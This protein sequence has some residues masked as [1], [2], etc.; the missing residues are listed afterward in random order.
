MSERNAEA[1]RRFYEAFNR[2]GLDA[3]SDRHFHEDVVVVEPSELPDSAQT[4][5]L[6]AARAGLAKFVDL[7]DDVVVAVDEILERDE[8]TLT[9][10]RVS[11]AGKESGAVV[12]TTRFDLATWSD[13][14]VTRIELFFD[15]EAA[16]AA[17][18]RGGPPEPGDEPGEG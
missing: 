10:I 2:E 17:F 15:R 8:R 6:Q 11:A 1:A 5:G 18:E 7:F 13:E 16:E 14:R 3:I 9:A 4:R 12:E